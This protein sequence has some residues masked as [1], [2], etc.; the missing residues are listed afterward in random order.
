MASVIDLHLGFDVVRE[1]MLLDTFAKFRK[2]II[3][4]I[5]PVR[6]SAWN[7][8]APAGRIFVKN[9][10]CVFFGNF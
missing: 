3:S 4:F 9:Y 2:A 7:N 6:P 1:L 10:I 5:M 8:S